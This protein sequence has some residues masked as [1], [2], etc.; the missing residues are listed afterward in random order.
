MALTI[1][2]TAQTAVGPS[3]RPLRSMAGP[4]QTYSGTSSV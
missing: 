3:L 4:E 2:R 1:P